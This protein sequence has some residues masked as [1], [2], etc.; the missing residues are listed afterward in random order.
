MVRPTVS[1]VEG[2]KIEERVAEAVRLVGGMSRVV[3]RGD[4]VL[5]KPNLV[6]GAPAETGE[7][8]HPE[9]LRELTELAFEAGAAEVSVGE[10]EPYEGR[11]AALYEKIRALVKPL[12]AIVVNFN[13]EPFDTVKVPEPVHFSEVKIARA[14]TRCDVFINAPT[15]KTHGLVGVTAAI[16][17]YYGVIPREDKIRYHKSDRV[18]EAIVDLYQ[19]RPSDL[20]VVDGTYSTIHWGPREDFPET[21]RLDLA[22]AGTDPV[23][24]DTVSAKVIGVEPKTLRYLRWAEERG[25]GVADLDSIRVVGAP[26]N[27]GRKATTTTVEYNNRRCRHIKILDFA[28]CTGCHGRVSAHVFA[29][30]DGE[31]KEDA[32]IVVGPEARQPTGGGKVILVGR[33][34]APTFFNRLKGTY[35]PG[36]PPNLSRLDSLLEELGAK[37]R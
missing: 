10:S 35:I 8:T 34:A 5:V 29:F 24:V 9:A 19:A 1:I 16:K 33:C 36:C 14:V 30:Q 17:N 27:A 22:L 21:H 20:V 12:G 37:K 2:M 31:M 32:T 11:R 6:D 18:E 13:D 28:S 26:V 15:L 23:A 4:K 7:T 3:G 25:L